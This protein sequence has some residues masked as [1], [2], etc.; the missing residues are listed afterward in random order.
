MSNLTE[1]QSRNRELA[2]HINEEA[3]ADP[4]SQYAG[5]KI[6]IANG[7]VVVVTD[8]WDDLALRLRQIESDPRRTFCVEA[9]MDYDAVEEIWGTL[10]S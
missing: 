4:H 5:K 10:S 8:D 9:G 6:G 3:R 7:Q 2:R 1:V